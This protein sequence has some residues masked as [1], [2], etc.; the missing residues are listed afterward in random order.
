MSKSTSFPMLPLRCISAGFFRNPISCCIL[1]K[2]NPPPLLQVSCLRQASEFVATRL[3]LITP[4]VSMEEWSTF[5]SEQETVS[6]RKVM[7]TFFRYL[8]AITTDI[9]NSVGELPVRAGID[10]LLKLAD[11]KA[12]YPLLAAECSQNALEIRDLYRWEPFYCWFFS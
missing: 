4:A 9:W 5:S 10:I 6:T 8:H 11:K 2:T 12:E 3:E 1:K 7:T